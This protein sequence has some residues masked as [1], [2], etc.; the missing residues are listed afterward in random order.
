MALK[1]GIPAGIDGIPTN[2]IPDNW[3]PIWFSSFIKLWLAKGDTRNALNGPG[4]SITGSINTPATISVSTD[5]SDVFHQEYLLAPGAAPPV[6]YTSYRTLA[7]ESGV[8]T[9]IDGGSTHPLTV[10][11]QT[12]GIGSAQ[13]RQVAADSLLGNATGAPANVADIALSTLGATPTTVVG[14]AAV[15][16][17]ALTFMR[18][19]GAPA[20]DQAISPTWTG[21]HAFSNPIVLEDGTPLL[22]STA[23]AG[24]LTT[25]VYRSATNEIGFTCNAVNVMKIGPAHVA[26][27]QPLQLAVGSNTTPSL[28]FIG[29]TATGL[30]QQAADGI[31]VTTANV[32]R[33]AISSTGVWTITGTAAGT[34][35][36]TLNTQATTGGQTASFSATNKPG[37]GGQ[38]TPA[39][40]L[41]VILD[42]TTYYV[43][44]F[45][46]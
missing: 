26:T 13:F 15:A 35:I 12:N 20:L 34:P 25:G 42:G 5:L 16:G 46:A 30:Y 11:I 9:I 19:D 43:P 10:G 31:A 33:L 27:A 4:I 17:S 44:A 40:W 6:S 14:L 29:S 23:F 3:D 32:Q 8:L 38:T 24:D 7:V 1:L 39:K 18:S 41:P 28:Y 22:P 37:T 45:A 36:L 2:S 21:S